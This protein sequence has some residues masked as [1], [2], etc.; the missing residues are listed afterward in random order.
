[1]ENHFDHSKPILACA[2]NEISRDGTC[3]L[4]FL[5]MS[6]FVASWI[7]RGFILTPEICLI[8]LSTVDGQPI[9]EMET[10]FSRWR[11]EAYKQN[12]PVV[13]N[14][15][16]FVSITFTPWLPWFHLFGSTGVPTRLGPHGKRRGKEWSETQ[17]AWRQFLCQ[18]FFRRCP[19]L[20]LDARC[21]C[22]FGCSQ[23]P[24]SGQSRNVAIYSASMSWWEIAEIFMHS[25][26]RL[27]SSVE[28]S[29]SKM[30]MFDFKNECARF[31]KCRCIERR[32]EFFQLSCN[33]AVL[34]IHPMGTFLC[35]TFPTREFELFWYFRI[36]RFRKRR[37]P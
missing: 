8:S 11:N 3:V 14:D 34:I 23:M 15:H 27:C 21:C 26:P 33:R 22:E 20:R 7:L 17:D 25:T 16:L 37:N 28:C 24:C 36:V 10:P 19:V 2:G 32:R 35:L 29:I 31:R 6:I 1:M 18:V 9:L 5:T 13:L 12:G 4:R 30:T